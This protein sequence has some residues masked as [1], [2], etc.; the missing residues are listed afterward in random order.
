MLYINFDCKVTLFFTSLKAF[1]IKKRHYDILD[2]EEA[3][4][5]AVKL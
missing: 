5:T 3:K 4:N 1:C 2:F